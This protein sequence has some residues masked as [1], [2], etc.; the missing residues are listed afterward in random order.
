MKSLLAILLALFSFK[1]ILAEEKAN[2]ADE[3]ILPS[4]LPQKVYQRY[5]T[6]FANHHDRGFYLSTTLGPQWNHSLKNPEAKAIRFGGKLGL[7]WYVADGVAL[8]G[9]AWGN[10]LEQASLVAGGPGVA[11]LFGGPNIGL[12]LSLGVGRVFSAVKKESYS[13]FAETVL[14]ANLSVAKFWWLSGST[15]L[16]VSLMSGVHGLTVTTGKLSTV[17]WNLGLGLAFLFG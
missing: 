4:S 2:S 14:A 10:F 16:G 9:A 5:Q 3:I 13:D 8:F 7:G 6:N 12:D 17:G 11:F 1:P 15:S